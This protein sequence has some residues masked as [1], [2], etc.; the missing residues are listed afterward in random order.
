MTYGFKENDDGEMI[1]IYPNF[2]NRLKEL[3][4][5]GVEFLHGGKKISLD[6]L[7]EKV[8]ER[9]TFEYF[10]RET[11]NDIVFRNT[12]NLKN[13]GDLL[14]IQI[15][16][17]VF[18]NN[19][20]LDEFKR[21][22]L[23]KSSS[24]QDHLFI[25]IIDLTLPIIPGNFSLEDKVLIDLWGINCRLKIPPELIERFFLLHGTFLK[26]ALRYQFKKVK[27]RNEFTAPSTKQSILELL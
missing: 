1:P 2:H 5:K 14:E 16:Q 9:G 7:Y 4:K 24:L 27:N 6:D 18:N 26:T 11:E 22:I 17:D 19:D 25:T 3:E 15:P 21:K 23:N 20:D 10:I 13:N 8:I 12:G